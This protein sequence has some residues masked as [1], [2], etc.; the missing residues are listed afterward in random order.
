MNTYIEFKG[1]KIEVDDIGFMP[2]DGVAIIIDGKKYMPVKH[3]ILHIV[4][5]KAD[6]EQVLELKDDNNLP[7]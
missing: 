1:K 6:V 2:E 3:Y 7:M 5:G 4:G